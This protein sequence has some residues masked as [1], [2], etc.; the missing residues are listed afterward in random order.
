MVVVVVVVVVVAF[1]VV[2]VVEEVV[3]ETYSQGRISYMFPTSP[4]FHAE[5]STPVNKQFRA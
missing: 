1:A 2:V 4:G 5:P 3:V